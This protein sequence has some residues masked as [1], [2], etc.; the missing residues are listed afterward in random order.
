MNKWWQDPRLDDEGT[1]DYLAEPLPNDYARWDLSME[2]WKCGECG[3][4]SRLMLNAAH[5]FYC[6][7]GWDSMDSSICWRCYLKGKIAEVK[8]KIERQRVV[9]KNTITLWKLCKKKDLVN[10]YKI[11]CRLNTKL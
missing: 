10:C 9:I 8:W 2:R 1:Y 5:Y 11:A 4:Y 6:Y 3:K 7:D